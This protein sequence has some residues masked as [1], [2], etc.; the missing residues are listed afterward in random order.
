[1]MGRHEFPGGACVD[2]FYLRYYVKPLAGY[3]HGH[4]KTWVTIQDAARS[5]IWT[6]NFQHRF[7]NDWIDWQ[8]LSAAEP[9]F[10]SQN[11]ISP[12]R[13]IVEGEWNFVEIHFKLNTPGVANGVIELWVDACGADGWGCTGSA[14]RVM[15]YTDVTMRDAGDNGL[16]CALWFENWS[17]PASKGEKYYDQVIVSRTGP[18]GHCTSCVSP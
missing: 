2:E 8:G 18:I 15:R 5:G 1:M 10:R 7:G 12:P 3:D 16:V 11:L 17:N 9:P 13:P 6:G 4:E 14:T